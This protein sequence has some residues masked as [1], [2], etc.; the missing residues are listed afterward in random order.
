MIASEQQH[1]LGTPSYAQC[2][3]GTK[4]PIRMSAFTAGLGRLSG[5]NTHVTKATFVTEAA[6]KASVVRLSNFR[7]R[8]RMS[9]DRLRVIIY[10]RAVALALAT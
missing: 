6:T 4:L 10:L 3:P 2:V 1:L 5:H 7:T 9:G 8:A